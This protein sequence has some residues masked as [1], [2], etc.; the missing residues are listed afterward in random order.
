MIELRKMIE[1]I[2]KKLIKK[3]WD[4]NKK[5]SLVVS[6]TQTDTLIYQSE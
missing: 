1:L 2:E 6:M 3:N 5:K 4:L